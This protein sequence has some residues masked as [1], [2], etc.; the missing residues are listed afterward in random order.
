MKQKF[1][2]LRTKLND[3]IAARVKT[4]RQACQ[5]RKIEYVDIEHETFDYSTRPVLKKGD[6]L[7]PISRG[8]N[9]LEQHLIQPEVTTFYHNNDKAFQIRFQEMIFERHNI[10]T[11]KTIHYLNP[12]Q[13]NLM[14]Y[15]NYIGGFPIILKSLGGTHGVGV[16]KI[17]SEQSLRSTLDYI[18]SFPSRLIMREFIPTNKSYRLIVLGDKVIASLEYRAAGKDFRSNRASDIDARPKKLSPQINQLAIKA[19]HVLGLEFGGVDVL[20]KPD[21]SAVIAEVNFPCNFVRAITNA[22]IPVAEMMID[23]LIAKAKKI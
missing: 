1:F 2:G 22:K 17:D 23:H 4:L 21:G 14:K 18:S 12:D 3:D 5:K 7:M 15:V 16:M 10:A 19:T 8:A 20:L 6:L 9:L 13:G 11:P